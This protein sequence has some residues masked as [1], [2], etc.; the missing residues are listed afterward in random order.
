MVVVE[1]IQVS[2]MSCQHCVN[3]VTKALEE[4]HG[5]GSALVSLE[6]S[7]AEV[8]FEADR[9]DLKTLKDAV[10][11]KGFG[12]IDFPA[13]GFAIAPP[14]PLSPGKIGA[15]VAAPDIGARMPGNKEIR[16]LSFRIE[17]MSCANCSGTIEKALRA[18]AG[19]QKASINFSMEK[20]FVG[21]D[22]NL[23]D[24]KGVLE[25]VNRAGYRALG[26]GAE[27]TDDSRLAA[28]ERF[29]FLFALSLTIPLTVLMYTM[30]F[31]H[32]NTNYLMA[33]LATL[34]Q[35]VSGRTFYEG[36]FHSLKNRSTNMDVLIALGISAAYFYSLFSLF[37]LDPA[38]HTFFDSSAMLITFIM[39]GKMIE[40]RAKGKTGLAL[41]KLM[42]LQADRARVIENGQERMVKASLVKVGDL[43]SVRPG[44][45]IPVD[46]EILEGTT[47]IDESMITGEPLPSEKGH[48]DLVTGATINRTGVI[49]IKA[50]R[51]GK[52]TMLARIVKMV[53]DAQADKAP[54][55]RLADVVSNYFVP[56]VVAVAL[57]TFFLWYF[58]LEYP[59]P[60]GVTRFLFSFQLMIAV[61]VVACPCALGLATPTAIMVASG[62]GLN[63]G[64][65]FKRA[66]VLETISHLDIVLFDKT[67]TITQ[68]KPRVSTV[69]PLGNRS[70]ADVLKIAAS[71]GANSVHPLAEA[72]VNKA[73]DEGIVL[74]KILNPSEIPG[75][76]TQGTLD[77]KKVM[78]GNLKLMAKDAVLSQE[79]VKVGQRLSDAGQSTV[80]VWYDNEMI[81]IIALADQVKTDSRE[82][83]AR[84]HALG[85][86]TA[87]ISGDNQKAAKAVAETVGID[88]VE[89]EV[90]PGEKSDIVKKW[91]AKGLKVG[92][93]GD[94][95]NDA[96]ALAQADIGIA[97]GSGTDIA[98]ETGDVILVNNTLLDVE[99]AIRLGRKTLSTIKVNFFW[100]FFYNILMIPIAAG[101][102]YPAL[103]LSLKPE[104]A[105]I[106]MWLS[107]L[108]VVGNSLLLKRVNL[109]NNG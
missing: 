90:L 21:Y 48:G 28:R 27:K 34:V 26:E 108:T 38:A 32:V 87:L 35:F 88:D 5:V 20:G 105:C 75:H 6:N 104:W 51:V 8:T 98:K 69:H 85:I 2:G 74:E 89:A 25:I 41:E 63:R 67:G 44:E 81:G 14:G 64:I 95:I 49:T 37:F 53:E 71:V 23:I 47:T 70:E 54:I 33:I 94:G 100:A 30:P 58:V 7:M 73:S 9:V 77:G 10:R 79:A 22:K 82:A 12:I 103:G 43:L 19:I 72:V 86:R 59:P 3:G 68:G 4:I 91:Q 17:G 40:A 62:V 52:A 66:S 99:R 96:P 39:V 97:V 16:E 45:T 107:S 13:A 31:G 65:L 1:K 101:L 61:L 56:V 60:V 29:R 50:V 80:Y 36:A 93:A 109:K 46:G 76:G 55:Q 83:I 11:A 84:L 106:A 57:L 102:L 42:S 15:T 78:V 24:G 18:T 92:M